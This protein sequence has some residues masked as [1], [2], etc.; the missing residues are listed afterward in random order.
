MIFQYSPNSFPQKTLNISSEVGLDSM[1]CN[2]ALR[3]GR[4][5]QV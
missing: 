4:L 3:N 5:C 2:K 1:L